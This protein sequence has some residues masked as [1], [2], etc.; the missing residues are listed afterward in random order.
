MLSWTIGKV[1]ITRVVESEMALPYEP[2]NIFIEEAKPDVLKQIPWLFPHYVTD[3]GYMRLSIHALLVE[4]PGLKLIVDTCIGN[5]KVRESLRGVALQ[6][7]FLE[8]LA[9][10]GF[11][12][13]AVDVVLCTHLHFDHVG[14]NT[15][16]A[17]GKWVPTFPNARYL[18]GKREY[19]H[20][21]T[22]EGASIL[23]QSE[24][25]SDS[26]RPVF[27]AGLATL[28]ET[29]HRVSP[30]IRLIPTPG[31]TP[32]HV[33]VMIESEGQVAVITGDMIH[34]PCQIAHPHWGTLVDSDSQASGL[35]RKRM[36]QNWA[37]QPVLVIGTHF[38]APTA[39]HV[40]RDGVSYRFHGA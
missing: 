36:L 8:D 29:D 9:A 30:E 37:D 26:V 13:D 16:K 7:A 10:A 5:D 23:E 15:M 24:V 4:A 2:G 32:G 3:E 17:G 12:R 20:W 6:T 22:A 18:I 21:A 19:E 27:E 14:W 38:A 40:R 1:R 25:L 11:A 28:V 35:T 33:S 31:H 39:G 34:H